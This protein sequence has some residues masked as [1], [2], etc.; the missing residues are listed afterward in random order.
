[1]PK[2]VAT[3]AKYQESGDRIPHFSPA[4]F[5]KNQNGAIATAE[6]YLVAQNWSL[7]LNDNRPV[8]VVC[9][10]PRCRQTSQKFVKLRGLAEHIVGGRIHAANPAIKLAI[11]DNG[12]KWVYQVDVT[13]DAYRVVENGGGT[14]DSYGAHKDVPTNIFLRWTGRL[15]S[16]VLQTTTR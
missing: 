3:K 15:W 6:Y 4:M 13:T 9:A 10:A 16:V 11:I 14:V 7:A 1:M 8:D 2:G 12:A 5:K